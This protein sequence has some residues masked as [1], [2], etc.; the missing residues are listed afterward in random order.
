MLPE[1]YL[2]TV[3]SKHKLTGPTNSPT[4]I[5]VYPVKSL[6]GVSLTS[7]QVTRLGFKYDRRFMLLKVIPSETKGETTLK[8]MHIPH[9]PE[10]ALFETELF[11]PGVDGEDE[12]GRLKIIYNH[13]RSG[14]ET[15][16]QINE[17]GPA[18]ER[19]HRDTI[20]VPLT[21]DTRGLDE[22]AIVMHRSP[23][24]GYNMGAKYNQWLSE[25]FGYEV[26][27]AYLGD[28]NS[29]SVLGTFAPAKHVA[30]KNQIQREL[31]LGGGFAAL[32]VV[33]GVLWVGF[34]ATSMPMSVVVAGGALGYDHSWKA[35]VGI[36]ATVAMGGLAYLSFIWRTGTGREDRITFA[37][38]AALLV[39]NETSVGNV[40][41]RLEG[42][43]EMDRRKFRANIVVEGSEMAYEE[44]FWAELVVGSSQI[45][46]LLTA[47]CARC[48]S[49]NVNFATGKFGTGDSGKVFKKLM[50][51]R[52]VD[53]GAKYS[54]IF[55]RYGFLDAK[56]DLKTVRVGD[57]VVVA[58][59]MDERAVYGKF[60]FEKISRIRRIWGESVTNPA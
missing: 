3:I 43:E 16:E 2:I 32:L 17:N 56:S 35:G 20:D 42:D 34:T 46:V 45:R 40:S 38:S 24:K 60:S 58:R 31:D 52:R 10:M 55:G 8:N 49:I 54:P 19:K 23:T 4:Q 25:R 21:P 28:G 36:G 39:I 30:H 18:K 11:E 7:A 33:L 50:A 13:P 47:N 12:R 26:V 1:Q 27:L 5:Y 41:S 53:K 6:R 57:D 37:D 29:R 51:D 9:L 14:S 48:Q 22:L 15:E 59:R 44:D